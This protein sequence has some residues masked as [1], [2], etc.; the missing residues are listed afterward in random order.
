LRF[1]EC[2]SNIILPAKLPTPFLM[3]RR[4]HVISLEEYMFFYVNSTATFTELV[5]LLNSFIEKFNISV[6]SCRL[7]LYILL[8]SFIYLLVYEWSLPIEI[9]ARILLQQFHFHSLPTRCKAVDL[10][11]F[12]RRFSHRLCMRPSHVAFAGRC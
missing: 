10:T 2:K 3:A 4:R 9:A 6:S 11:T 1:N 7:V 5:S 8:S 12:V